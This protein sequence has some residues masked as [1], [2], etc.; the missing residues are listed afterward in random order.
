MEKIVHAHDQVRKL[1]EVIHYP[2]HEKRTESEEFIEIRKRLHTHPCYISN[3]F[4]E[5]RIEIHHSVIEWAASNEVD[6]AKV[7]SELGFDHVD[8]E[9]QMMPLC[10]KHHVGLGTGIHEI[11]YPAWILQ[12][13]LLPDSLALFEAAV[14]HLKDQGHDDHHVN[15]AAKKM[16]L[17]LSKAN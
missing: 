8:A 1:I 15:H 13:F 17:H 9:T 10:H 2:D 3:G 14:Q 16:L 5:G 4:C 6:W 11:T 12:R 7:Q